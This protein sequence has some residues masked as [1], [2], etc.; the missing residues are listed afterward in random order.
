MTSEFL[1]LKL[2]YGPVF[3]SVVLLPSTGSAIR[4]TFQVVISLCLAAGQRP[5]ALVSSTKVLKSNV[6]TS[7]SGQLTP[8]LGRRASTSVSPQLSASAT[9][10]QLSDLTCSSSAVGSTLKLRMR[11]SC[12]VS[13][14][15]VTK[16]VVI[17]KTL[18]S[19]KT[20][21]MVNNRWVST[22]MECPKWTCSKWMASMALSSTMANISKTMA[23]RCDEND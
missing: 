7:R 23:S 14:Q 16:L 3:V 20:W 12:C 4:W 17:N 5:P 21:M 19:H 8:C 22:P 11:S 18:E 6:I 15:T 9:H 2:S 10:P 13:A 1:I